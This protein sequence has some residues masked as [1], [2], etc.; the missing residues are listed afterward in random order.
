MP[1]VKAGIYH[2]RT[3]LLVTLLFIV[4]PFL[5][6]LIFSRLANIASGALLLNVAIS[7]AR[8]SIAYIIAAILAW[9][10]AVSFYQGRQAAIALPI[11]DVLQ[12]FPTFALLPLAT[13]FWGPSNFTIIF[14]L[15]ITVIWPL[16]FSIVS[17]LKLIRH[18]WREAVK[19]Y[20]LSGFAYLKNFL[21]PVTIPG[22]ITG[23]VVG[24][25]EG[26]EALIAT[27]IIVG[28]KSGLG[29]F[30]QTHSTNI[31]ITI[32]GVLGFLILIFTVNRV[33]WLPLLE[34]SHKR[35]ED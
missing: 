4:V 8:L 1:K 23:S 28:M 29:S 19:I 25:G 26:W 27:E 9:I 21:W 24:L 15:V 12:S 22:F 34:R 3:H 16:F 35:M 11:F 20:N 30:F 18:D 14:F 2:S 31:H 13:L 32:F 33:I 7:A 6:L 17:S 5:F 10:F